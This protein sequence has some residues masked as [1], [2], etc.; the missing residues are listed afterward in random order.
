MSCGHEVEVAMV[1]SPL[2]RVDISSMCRLHWRGAQWHW[3]CASDEGCVNM[4]LRLGTLPIRTSSSMDRSPT[5]KTR[6]SAYPWPHTSQRHL[7]HVAI[8]C[9]YPESVI[10]SGQHHTEIVSEARTPLY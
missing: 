9:G 6:F 1:N 4:Q 2:W 5:T 7:I 8:Y 3:R 10:F